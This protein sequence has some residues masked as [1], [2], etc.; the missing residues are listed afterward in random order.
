MAHVLQ[1][2]ICVFLSSLSVKGHPKSWQV[3][4]HDQQFGENESIDIGKSQRLRKEGIAPIN[5]VSAMS[6]GL[7]MI[8]EKVCISRYFESPETNLHIAKNTCCIDYTY[9]WWSKRLHW[10]SKSLSLHW[11]TICYGCEDTL[12]L[13][14]GSAWVSLLI[15]RIHPLVALKFNI[16]W[17]LATIHNTGWM[18][19]CKVHYGRF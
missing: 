18:D 6:S 16:P 8:F 4:E 13:A 19:H 17:F 14:S 7:A 10:L 9:T 5:N 2:A 3:H 11:G 12:E 15:A 1:L